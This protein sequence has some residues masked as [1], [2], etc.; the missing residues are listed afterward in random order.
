MVDDIQ[1]HLSFR[2]GD[3]CV[4]ATDAVS[5]RAIKEFRDDGYEG[6]VNA[7]VAGLNAK[8]R[9]HVEMMIAESTKLE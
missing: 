5:I 7:S 9:A 4:T 8:L 3:V 1:V 6:L 2:V